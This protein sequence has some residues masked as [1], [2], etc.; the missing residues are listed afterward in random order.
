MVTSCRD[1]RSLCSGGVSQPL[2]NKDLDLSERVVYA[3][4][5]KRL[6]ISDFTNC[7]L[8]IM[9]FGS[10]ANGILLALITNS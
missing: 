2:K 5:G 4:M 3:V 9:E 10:A 7:A 6:Y 1:H 8:S